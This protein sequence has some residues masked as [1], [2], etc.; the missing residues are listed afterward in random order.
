MKELEEIKED[1]FFQ[2]NFQRDESH[3]EFKTSPA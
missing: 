2:N 1:D 3:S